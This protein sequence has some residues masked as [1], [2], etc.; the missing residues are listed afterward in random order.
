M[1]KILLLLFCF[2]IYIVSFAQAPAIEWQK[3]YGGSGDEAAFNLELTNDGGFIV[4]G[5]SA[6]ADGDV[7]NHHGLSFLSDYWI[8]KTYSSGIIQW[9]QSLGGTGADE[10]YSI[11]QTD[12]GGYVIA[13]SSY[14]NDGDVSGH[15]GSTSIYDYW[16]VKINI[17]GNIE[18]QKSLGG[19][20]EDKA[21]I[22]QLTNDG[23][24]IVA[25][26]SKSIDGDV[27]GNHGNQDCWVVKL[28]NNGNISWQKSYGGTN[29]DEANFIEQT[30]DGGY[31]LA[32][33]SDSNDGDVSGNHG[34]AG[35]R[36]F[37]IIKI[38]ISG[39]IQWQKTYGGT[40]D[41]GTYSIHQT[42]DNGYI[43][44]GWAESNDGDASGNHGYT[45]Y[46]IVKTN[47]SG[48]I[49]WQKCLGGGVGAEIAYSLKETI[50]GG[51]IIAGEAASDDGDV[52]GNHGYTD[53]WVV[54]IN[55]TGNIQWQ[56]CLGGA[57]LLDKATSINLTNDSGYIVTGYSRSTNGDVTGNHGGS[58]YWTVK[59]SG[60]VDIENPNAKNEISIY[61]SRN[62][63]F[64][65]L[66]A[67]TSQPTT[68]T[69]YNLLGEV[70]TSASFNSKTFQ[71]QL[72]EMPASVLL[73]RVTSNEFDVTK[74]VVFG[75]E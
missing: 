24:Y 60:I 37:W 1:K 2:L 56:K 48:D 59:L 72:P 73:V 21:K 63:L 29:D 49:Q 36:D 54:K 43:I 65:T 8:V 32:G 33:W 67:Q 11:Q 41:D 3:S 14:S 47:N 28:E 4:C 18:W 9:Q 35:Y 61:N 75:V 31:I 20:G 30:N 46:W 51:Y 40:S 74:K 45:D 19:T 62:Q 68:A 69:V 38:D 55:S 57:G 25:G 53:Y 70:I 7:T 13:G 42:N 66:P 16:I 12:D 5:Y 23:G 10:A 34:I 52:S 17:S 64:I 26:F 58:D 15:H 22:I 44:S 71:M 27:T 39:N 6:S 50:D